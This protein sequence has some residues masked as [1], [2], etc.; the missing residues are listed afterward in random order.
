VG[1]RVH[2]DDIEKRKYFT[3]PGLELRRLDRPGHSQ[4]LYRLGYPG[5]NEECK[6]KMV[7]SKFPTAFNFFAGRWNIFKS[8][9]LHQFNSKYNNIC[10]I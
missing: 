8:R 5:S 4:S 3:L 6:L 10:G 9:I 1:P 7:H 2:L